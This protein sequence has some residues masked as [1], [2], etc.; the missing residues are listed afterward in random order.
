MRTLIIVI[1]SLVYFCSFYTTNIHDFGYSVSEGHLANRVM[2]AFIHTNIVHLSANMFS[3]YFL[4]K[5]AVLFVEKRVLN[6]AILIIIP[7]VTMGTAGVLPTIGFSG[8]C[9]FLFGLLF[10]ANPKALIY[11]VGLSI[12]VHM[13]YFL[14]HYNVNVMVHLLGFFYGFFFYKLYYTYTNYDKSRKITRAS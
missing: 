14:L 12:V 4:Y 9:F 7:F 2:Y 5:S 8:V 3:F 6:V 1:C 13:A 11:Y 10:G